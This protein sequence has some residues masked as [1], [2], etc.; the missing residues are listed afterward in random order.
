MATTTQQARR[1]L[2]RT[3]L[4]QRFGQM[5]VLLGVLLAPGQAG[6]AQAASGLDESAFDAAAKLYEGGHPADAAAAYEKLL[7]NG[8]VTPSVLFN[9]G[10][11]WLHA[12]KVGRAI[13]SY[14]RASALAPRDEEIF[15]NLARA[16]SK[17]GADAVT[18]EGFGAR[19]LR[20]LTPNEWAAL[21]T[22]GVWAWFGSL[23][24][25]HLVPRLRG[26]S[27]AAVRP[28]AGLA[29]ILLALASTS[30]WLAGRP[31]AVVIAADTTARF[32]PLEESQTAFTLPDGAEVVV[33]DRKGDWLGV[34]DA[35][36]RRG[37]V[38][39]RNLVTLP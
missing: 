36:G 19:A 8:V 6:S 12:G 35:M 7:T 11:A 1:V 34:R 38:M 2:R 10:N 24:L 33:T 31:S 9:Q 39:A 25:G 14:R 37:W 4:W 28:M 18:V 13:V 3:P 23:T 22:V 5:V 26:L 15:S 16:R 17:V 32:G 21:A 20:V 27:Q 29:L 30:A